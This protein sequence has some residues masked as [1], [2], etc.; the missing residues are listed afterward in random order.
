MEDI[1]GYDEQLLTVMD[2][3]HALKVSHDREVDEAR[4]ANW[5]SRCTCS[6]STRMPHH[7]TP[8]PEFMWCSSC[9]GYFRLKKEEETEGPGSGFFRT[10]WV[11]LKD[12]GYYCDEDRFGSR[13]W[14]CKSGL[15][16]AGYGRQ[17]D[18]GLE[19]R[20]CVKLKKEGVAKPAGAFTGRFNLHADGC[21][22]TKLSEA[23]DAAGIDWKSE[24][25]WWAEFRNK[26]EE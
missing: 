9:D 13:S 23:G 12:N 14:F 26:E 17:V 20:L 16:K 1:K 8:E 10:P 22:S 24:V 6:V 4:K 7:A 2:A 15:W 19:A 21:V 25:Y 11:R 5:P 18:D 3:F